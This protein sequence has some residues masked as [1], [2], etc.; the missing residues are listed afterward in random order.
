MA[1]EAEGSRGPELSAPETPASTEPE[2]LGALRPTAMCSR[3]EPRT[4]GPRQWSMSTH[5]R[6]RTRSFYATTHFSLEPRQPPL[7]VGSILRRSD[8]DALPSISDLKWMIGFWFRASHRYT[9]VKTRCN[10][11]PEP[12]ASIRQLR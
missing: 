10:S 11:R 5:R 12:F 2:R 1:M 8:R 9:P 3:H 4:D 7:P 6:H